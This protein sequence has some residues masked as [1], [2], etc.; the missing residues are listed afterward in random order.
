MNT[1]VKKNWIYLLGL[2]LSVPAF[3]QRNNLVMY[4]DTI[5]RRDTVLTHVNFL[6]DDSHD[7]Q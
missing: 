2:L 4:R 5:T 7:M 6:S 1:I 3:S